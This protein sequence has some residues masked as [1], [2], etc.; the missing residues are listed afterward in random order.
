MGR[1]RSRRR[2]SRKRRA[3][4]ARHALLD[5]AGLCIAA[6]GTDYIRAALAAWDAEGPC[7]ALGHGRGLDA[8]GAAFV[9]GTAAHGEDFD[10]SFEGTPVHAGAVVVPAVLAA[11]E[12]YGLLRRRP[13]ARLRGRR[14][15]DVPARPGG[16]D[17]D[18]PRGLPSDRGVRR[19]R[20][21][22]RGRRCAPPVAP[23]ADRCARHRRQHGVRHHRVSR[24]GHLD[25]AHA[26]RLGRPGGPARG[27]A[28]ARGLPRPAHGAR[29]RARLL[30][31]L[32]HRR[33]HARLPL[34]DGRSR[35]PTGRWRR[36]RSSPT[37][38]APCCTR[39]STAPSGSRRKAWRRAEVARGDLPGR[40]GHRAPALGAARR[41]AEAQHVR[42]PPSSAAR[43]P[44]RSA[45]SSRRRAS[46]SSPRPRCAIPTCW[47]SP[48]RSATRSTPTN[49]YPRNYTGD[50]RVVLRDGSVR[51]A[52]QP[53]LRGGVREPLGPRRDHRENS[54]PTRRSAAGRI[55]GSTPSRRSAT[56]RFGRSD[57]A[58]LAAFRHGPDEPLRAE[59]HGETQARQDRAG[60]RP[61]GVRRQRLRLDR[62]SRPPRSRCSTRSW[63]TVS[64]PSTRR[65]SIR[66]GSHGNAGGESETIIGNWLKQRGGRER[67]VLIT[68]VG[69][70]MGPGKKG[71]SRD[72][73]MACGRGLAAPPADRPHR[74]L[75]VASTRSEARRSRR[76]SRPI[77]AWSSRARCGRSA[78]RTTT[79]PG[80]RRRSRRAAPRDGRATRS[81]SRSTT[82]TIA[83]ATRRSSS[84][85]S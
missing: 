74:S 49:E 27:A 66:A 41:E 3:S 60:D 47:R 22:R 36:S 70:E 71:L 42:T 9:N 76:R 6:R 73:I 85:W 30:P 29:G 46:S 72:Y 67:V 10:D 64:T 39:S 7:T 26:R 84:L 80:S 58:G 55:P 21:R 51:E 20:R 12:R 38:A 34:R 57:L 33:H 23:A 19:A 45:W 54:A 79:P 52:Q 62:R 2:R 16:A 14:R 48:P 24:R 63:R 31:R 32:R 5:V 77:S 11:A 28:R 81:C 82:S 18:P 44:S 40:R 1:R 61:A 75:P 50:V 4:V 65:T 17:R 37:P 83:P 69:S 56:M 35:A 68:K 78:A 25:Q 59:D 43:S 13:A 8:A 53:Y 15:A